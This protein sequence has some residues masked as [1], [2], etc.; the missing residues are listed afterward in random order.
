MRLGQLAPLQMLSASA[1]ARSQVT[2]TRIAALITVVL[3]ARLETLPTVPASL[4]TSYWVELRLNNVRGEH[5]L[6]QSHSSL[7]YELI[8][9]TLLRLLDEKIPALRT[10]ATRWARIKFNQQECAF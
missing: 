6:V 8:Q 4:A 9:G 1:R 5:L 7:N 2:K 3:R 10:S